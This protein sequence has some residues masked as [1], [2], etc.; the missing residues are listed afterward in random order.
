MTQQQQSERKKNT[1][2]NRKTKQNPSNETRN[3]SIHALSNYNGTEQNRT[4]RT[5]NF[6]FD[7][8][9]G[10]LIQAVQRA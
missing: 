2:S 3:D 4:E 9:L 7:R 6:F 8:R 1:P 10:R 5:G